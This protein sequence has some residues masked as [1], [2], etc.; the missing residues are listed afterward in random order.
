MINVIVMVVQIG[1]GHG[2]PTTFGPFQT[3]E[4]C[5]SQI[6]AIIKQVEPLTN[7]N[8]FNLPNARGVCIEYNR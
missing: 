7:G 3:L 1:L 6:P 4:S 5:N 8:F 2:G